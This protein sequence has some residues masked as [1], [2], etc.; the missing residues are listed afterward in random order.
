MAFEL[1]DTDRDGLIRRDQFEHLFNCFG[2][3]KGEQDVWED[4]LAV[5]DKNRDGRLSA[6]EFNQA[7][8]NILMGG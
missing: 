3:A 4:L 5:V 1:L 8:G 2:G 7:M 6:E